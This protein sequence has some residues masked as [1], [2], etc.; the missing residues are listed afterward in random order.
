LQPSWLSRF[1][2]VPWY[3]CVNSINDGSATYLYERANRLI[4]ETL[5]G[6]TSL[7]AYNGDG[8]RLRQTISSI[9]IAG[10]VTTYT[11]DLA[12][13]LPVVLQS[14]S[15]MTTTRYL[16]NVGTQPLAQSVAA[17]EYLLPDAL[18]SVRQI[19]NASGNIIRTQDY[20][21]Y[22]SP[23][24]GSGSGQSVYGFTG[25]ERD[26]Y[27]K[28]VFLRA[29]Y[30][31]PETGGFLSKDVWQGDYT[32][33][34]SLNGWGYGLGNPVTLIVVNGHHCSMIYVLSRMGRITIRQC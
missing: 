18:G 23:M 12:A 25:E 8:A 11:Q 1:V 2:V 3:N 31:R 17:W 29:R 16:Y 26:S 33:P 6:V 13:P 22:G 28:L 14:R 34:Q 24:N 4:S 10:T 21:P 20:E 7:Y 9:E 30:Y 19:A 32:R 27:S 15:G 5:S